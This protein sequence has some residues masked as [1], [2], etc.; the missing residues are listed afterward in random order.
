MLTDIV[1]RTKGEHMLNAQEN[2]LTKQDRC[3]R[4]GSEAYVRVVLPS[5]NDLMFCGHHWVLNKA[6]ITS[7]EDVLIEDE[8]ARLTENS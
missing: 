8:L 1:S 5:G 6:T 2:K 7:L 4:C 3:D